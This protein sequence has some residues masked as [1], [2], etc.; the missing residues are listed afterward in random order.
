[1]AF[2]KGF[3]KVKELIDASQIEYN[4]LEVIDR[5]MDFVGGA[6]LL[7]GDVPTMIQYNDP[8]K[9]YHLIFESIEGNGVQAESTNKE[10][11]IDLLREIA[12]G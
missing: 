4:D 1:M 7:I 3:A 11:V 9:K 12:K 2:N 8:Q 6:Y 10:V 5:D